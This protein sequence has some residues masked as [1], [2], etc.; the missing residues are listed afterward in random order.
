M[1][2]KTP[3]SQLTK[4]IK[5]GAAILFIGELATFGGSYIVWHQLNTNPGMI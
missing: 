2:P 4:F 5:R 3:K 1:I